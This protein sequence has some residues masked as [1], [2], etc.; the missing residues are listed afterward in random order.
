[1]AHN[2]DH[3]Y[4]EKRDDGS[5]AGARGGAKRASVVGLTQKA[6][7]EQLQEMH[8]GK[9]IHVERVRHTNKGNPDKWR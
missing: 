9:P 2:K 3:L 5:F 4:V 7:V 1:M 6:V 8:P